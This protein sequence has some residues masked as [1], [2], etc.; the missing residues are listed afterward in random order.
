MIGRLDLNT[1]RGFRWAGAVLL[2]LASGL[3]GCGSGSSGGSPQPGATSRVNGVVAKGRVSGAVVC[4]Y[5]IDAGAVSSQLG[6]CTQ[7][8][9]QGV[10]QLSFDGTVDQ[11]IVQAR[12]GTYLDEATG[13]PLDPGTLRTLPTTRPAD[14]IYW[15]AHVTP[16]TELVVRRA[17]A[18]GPLSTERINAAADEV[19]QSF[20]IGASSTEP[21]DLT[22][23]SSSADYLGQRYGLY[24]AGISAMS[25]GSDLSTT[26]DAIGRDITNKTMASRNAAFNDGVTR[27]LNSPRNQSGIP[28]SDLATF[29]GSRP[30]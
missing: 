8:D 24:L 6:N 28:A 14:G 30:F 5:R 21:S 15:V 23:R 9:A 18:S 25:A 1:V 20:K 2:A 17:I 16:I 3:V 19:L 22:V 10:Y 11:L 26:L 27:F 12:G 13:N 4:A 29:V 7:T